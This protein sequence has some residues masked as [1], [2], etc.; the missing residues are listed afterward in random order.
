MNKKEQ[1]QAFPTVSKL[2][3]FTLAFEFDKTLQEVKR[4]VRIRTY[5][6]L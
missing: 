1:I 5:K 2:E 6:S 3:S 4:D